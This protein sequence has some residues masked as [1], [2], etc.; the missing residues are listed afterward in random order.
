MTQKPCLLDQLKVSN[1]IIN[2][3]TYLSWPKSLVA[4]CSYTKR[5]YL[6]NQV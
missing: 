4:H 5:V 1:A 2:E 6:P 3:D